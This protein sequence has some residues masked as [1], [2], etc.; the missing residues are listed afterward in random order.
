M[1]QMNIWQ[2]EPEL[3][4]G[5]VIYP[6]HGRLGP[7]IQ[8]NLQL[9]YVWDGSARIWINGRRSDLQAGECILLLPH[10]RERFAFSDGSSTHHGW[11]EARE[12]VLEPSFG[13]RLGSIEGQVFRTPGTIR[14]LARVGTRLKDDPRWGARKAYFALCG[15]VLLTFAAD[16]GI[17]RLEGAPPNDQRLPRALARAI[18]E[19]HIK[20]AR[21]E[22]VGAIATAAGVSQQHLARLFRTHLS[23]TP[24]EYLWR[25]RTEKAVDLIRSTGLSLTEVAR[26]SGFKTQFH[27]SRRVRDHT[28]VPPSELRL[29]DDSATRLR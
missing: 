28:G 14:D 1:S 21:I 22:G 24:H 15:A 8:P 20:T 11:V 6:P 10:R 23:T 18:D 17:A 29:G 2:G 27:L 4:I 13:G 5:D 19:I 7:R 26:Q 3:T 12:P 16:A 25:V 9:V